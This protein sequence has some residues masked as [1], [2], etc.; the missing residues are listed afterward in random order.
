WDSQDSKDMIKEINS[1][2][3]N[4]E[5]KEY[6]VVSSYKE[7]KKKR[8][9]NINN[10]TS[11]K[12]DISNKEI[13]EKEQNNNGKENNKDKKEN[14]DLKESRGYKEMRES[15]A[16]KFINKGNNNNGDSTKQKGL[17]AHKSERV[18]K[19]EKNN[20]L[21]KQDLSESNVYE[22]NAVLA[23]QM[24][25][26]NGNNPPNNISV[27]LKHKHSSTDYENKVSNAI[28]NTNI[29]QSNPISQINPLSYSANIKV[30]VNIE[31]N[32]IQI[33]NGADKI[34]E[35]AKDGQNHSN[36]KIQ[37]YKKIQIPTSNNL[38]GNYRLKKSRSNSIG[39][40]A[41][42]RGIVVRNLNSF[43]NSKN[44]INFSAF[45]ANNA[46]NTSQPQINPNILNQNKQNAVYMN[47]NSKNQKEK[48]PNNSS[49]MSN[50]T[51]NKKENNVNQ[52]NNFANTAFAFNNGI[53]EGE[54]E[55]GLAPKNKKTYTATYKKRANSPNPN[56][57]G[58]NNLGKLNLGQNNGINNIKVSESADIGGLIK[59]RAD[60]QNPN[61]NFNK[62]Q[63]LNNPFFKHNKKSKSTNKVSKK[64]KQKNSSEE[65]MPKSASFYKNENVEKKVLTPPHSQ[66]KKSIFFGLY[67]QQNEK[68]KRRASSALRAEEKLR[69][70]KYYVMPGNNAKLVERVIRTRYGWEPV[71]EDQ[72]NNAGLYW[73]PLSFQLNLAKSDNNIQYVNHIEH[74]SELG[75]KMK[76]FANLMNYCEFSKINLFS[77]FPL[78]IIFQISHSS[79]F[80][81]LRKLEKFYKDIENFIEGN[82]NNAGQTVNYNNYW[83]ELNSIT[84]QPVFT[85]Y[86]TYLSFFNVLNSKR[87][88]NEQ[89]LEIPKTHYVGKNLWIIKP[90][91]FNRGR[92]IKIFSNIED[93]TNYLSKIQNEKG[94]VTSA[95]KKVKADNIIVQKYIESPLLYKGRKFDIRIWVLITDSEG[96]FI[97]KEGHLKA[98]SENFDIDSNN[99][100]VHLTNYSVQKHGTNFSKVEIG[101]EISF[102]EFQAELNKNTN[103][104]VNFRKEIYPK[105]CNII[106]LSYNSVRSKIGSYYGRNCFEI[107]GYDFIIDTEFNPFLLEINT[108][109]GLEESSPLIKMLVPRMIDDAL[110]LTIDTKFSKRD[111]DDTP[112]T[113]PSSFHVDGYSDTENMWQ[114]LTKF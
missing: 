104:V 99:E 21:D 73:C 68:K 70:R 110:K 43:N 12:N 20:P 91:N 89:K 77:F 49:A 85:N 101:N 44:N 41:F 48:N 112:N 33:F 39:D 76:L 26:N 105:I 62:T 27:K 95:N 46:V 67:N 17:K 9:A 50:N 83:N 16:K 90:T 42:Q 3:D 14:K 97:F 60:S 40:Y 22:R 19:V 29:N 38:L 30:Q 47:N 66:N 93:I 113:T 37:K 78:T 96:I 87:I 45:L 51:S 13:K 58:T 65:P 28:A 75:N 63:P 100:F 4:K 1:N 36:D 109:P 5:I 25:A 57:S 81:Q 69:K 54:N 61:K 84:G 11:N 59:N 56:F 111:N 10:S 34:K 53:N 55:V 80:E 8:N 106:R 86:A 82:P 102:A 64:K 32:T 6:K 108:N 107:F 71:E 2:N 24:A 52:S 31:K 98:T 103:P 114:K 88:G 23:A 7:M 92:C 79:F 35:N 74:G 15:R 18:E 94:F 72:R